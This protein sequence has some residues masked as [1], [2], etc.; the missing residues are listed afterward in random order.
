MAG[1]AVLI[2]AGRRSRASALRIG[3][4]R[5]AAWFVR[6]ALLQAFNTETTKSHGAVRGGSDDISPQ[7]VLQQPRTEIQQQAEARTDH[8]KVGHINP[9]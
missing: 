5:L 6:R 1:P 3:H 9:R 8:P 7:A 2:R 4:V